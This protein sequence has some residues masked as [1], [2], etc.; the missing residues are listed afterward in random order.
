[1]FCVFCSTTEEV[2]ILG[3]LR[4]FNIIGYSVLEVG[5][6]L[7]TAHTIGIKLFYLKKNFQVSQKTIIVSKEK[8][9]FKVTYQKSLQ[10]DRAAH[11]NL[12]HLLRKN[13]FMSER[14]ILR[15]M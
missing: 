12:S 10:H 13:V 5:F 2:S 1:M 8:K 4:H 3:R 15:A 9:K 14:S 7:L 6:K 11:A